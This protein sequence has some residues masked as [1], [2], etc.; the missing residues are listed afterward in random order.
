MHS[1]IINTYVILNRNCTITNCNVYIG[2]SHVNS[3]RAKKNT[4]AACLCIC[5][6][7]APNCIDE[8]ATVY[9]R[10]K[11]KSEDNTQQQ[12]TTDNDDDNND[13]TAE[14]KKCTLFSN[15]LFLSHSLQ[16]K[17]VRFEENRSFLLLW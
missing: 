5:L 12:Q 7:Y 14:T 8:F 4:P 6:H 3:L 2:F 15:R 13:V 9:S 17:L 10:G 16:T 1:Q 11:K